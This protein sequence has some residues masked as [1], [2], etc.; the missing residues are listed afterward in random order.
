[1]KVVQFLAGLVI[2]TF[3]PEMDMRV[4]KRETLSVYLCDMVN[5]N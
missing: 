2:V 4:R 5:C 1:M 3:K